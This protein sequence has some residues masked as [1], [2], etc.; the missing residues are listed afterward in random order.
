M[1]HDPNYPMSY[2]ISR[3]TGIPVAGH[4][5]N[6]PDECP[7]RI[8]RYWGERWVDAGTCLACGERNHGCQAKQCDH[9]KKWSELREEINL[10]RRPRRRS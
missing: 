5:W 8:L 1:A 4:F 2:W 9:T 6:P 10:N 3:K 7:H